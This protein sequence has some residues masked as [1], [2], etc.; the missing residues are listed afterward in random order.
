MNTTSSTEA[1]WF[2]DND[3][4]RLTRGADGR[5]WH[6]A[7]DDARP[8][9]VRRCFPWSEPGRFVSLRDDSGAEVA[10]VSHPAELDPSSREALESALAEAGFLLEVT[11]IFAVKDEVEV[12]HWRVETR[13]GPRRFQ[14]RLDDWP[15]LLPGGGFLLRDVS[16]DLYRIPEPEALDRHGQSLLSPFVD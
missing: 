6:G 9:T 10:L 12:R 3:A 13:Q 16:G 11:R 14:T 7:G 15:R 4:P 5:L 1:E 2:L 8:V